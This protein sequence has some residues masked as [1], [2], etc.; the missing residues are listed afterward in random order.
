VPERIRPDGS[1]RGKF[2]EEGTGKCLFFNK[3]MYEKEK[4]KPKKEGAMK[5]MRCVKD[6]FEPGRLPEERIFTKGQDY[7]VINQTMDHYF[8]NNSSGSDFHAVKKNHGYFEPIPDTS[9]PS[10]KYRLLKAITG[11]SLLGNNACHPELGKFIIKYGY[12]HCATKQGFRSLDEYV[13]QV[14]PGNYKW[15]VKKG[16]VERIYERTYS[17]GQKFKTSWGGNIYAIAAVGEKQVQLIA[18][19]FE[20]HYGKPIRVESF[21]EI[22]QAEMDQMVSKDGFDGVIS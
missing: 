21:D 19:D 6:F 13:A 2:E 16:Y 20:A 18:I 9:E 5:K 1:L 10:P 8:L 14:D 12:D 15:L 7:E 3:V 22:T 4:Y 11:R 17:V